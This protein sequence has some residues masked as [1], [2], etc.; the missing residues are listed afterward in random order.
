MKR[1]LA[2][3]LSVILMLFMFSGCSVEEIK[4]NLENPSKK[5]NSVEVIEDQLGF[6]PA[7]IP[8]TTGFKL[9][10][11]YIIDNRIAELRYKNDEGDKASV[12]SEEGSDET[13]NGVYDVNYSI[14]AY[15]GIQ[16]F[17]GQVEGENTWAGYHFDKKDN[18]SITVGAVI[19]GTEKDAFM[20]DFV[21]IVNSTN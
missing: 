4:Y 15:R 2:M 12:R 21:Q 16:F 9:D 8:E 7:Q 5:V 13:I 18:K 11:C 17:M 20:Y 1:R 14:V 19:E 3:G 10:K 6:T